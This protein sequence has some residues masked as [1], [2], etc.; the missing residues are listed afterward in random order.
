MYDAFKK[1]NMKLLVG[2]EFDDC[3]PTLVRHVESFVAKTGAKVRLTHV[4]SPDIGHGWIAASYGVDLYD[5]IA[6]DEKR[7]EYESATTRLKQIAKE[8]SIDSVETNVVVGDAVG[9]LQ[10]DAVAS[11]SSLIMVGTNINREQML[12]GGFSTSLGLMTESSMPVMAVPKDA[13]PLV[14]AGGMLRLLYGDDLTESSRDALGVAVEMAYGVGECA[15]LH[16]HICDSPHSALESFGQK[17]LDLM[18]ANVVPMDD[19]IDSNNFSEKTLDRL[20]E[21]MTHRLGAANLLLTAS[22]C[23]YE[24]R[25]LTGD[26]QETFQKAVASMEPDVLIFGRH[27]FL[28]H[29]PL[30]IGKLPFAAML[31]LKKPVVVVPPRQRSL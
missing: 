26:V 10:A 6:R 5:E 13:A 14:S 7:A 11:G 2:V 19:G 27:S 23:S 16:V 25:V 15:F 24:K 29:K 8:L 20:G 31:S 28:H 30:G 3:L 9:V 1:E 22:N 18:D 4:I 17:V 12:P 21:K